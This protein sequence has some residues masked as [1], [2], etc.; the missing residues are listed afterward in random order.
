MLASPLKLHHK[1]TY[2]SNSFVDAD[3]AYLKK[4][5]L[6]REF[7]Q[8]HG[9]IDETLDNSPKTCIGPDREGYR[10][11]MSKLEIIKLWYGHTLM[12]MRHMYAWAV[13]SLEALEMIQRS[14]DHNGLQGVIE[15]GAGT[16]YWAMQ[17][18]RRGIDVV[19]F[20]RDIVFDMSLCQQTNSLS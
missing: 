19:A 4:F 15:I 11:A 1:T 6:T 16:G 8:Y 13:P 3:T 10:G 18:Q 12:P 9:L 17:L 5:S 14:V 20:D 7:G 2:T